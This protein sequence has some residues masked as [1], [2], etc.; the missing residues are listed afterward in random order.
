M[1][2]RTA[3]P[4][5]FGWRMFWEGQARQGCL[6]CRRTLFFF[7]TFSFFY[8][9]LLTSCLSSN[10]VKSL[11]YGITG[12]FGVWLQRRFLST[13]SVELWGAARAQVTVIWTPASQRSQSHARF[14]PQPPTPVMLIATQI[15]GACRSPRLS[16]KS[17]FL[18]A[19]SF[20]WAR[21]RGRENKAQT[22]LHMNARRCV[23]LGIFVP[24]E[25]PGG[26]QRDMA[27]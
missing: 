2:T 10:L 11:A 1:C 7:L 6:M 15:G 19:F 9:V 4:K 18:Q 22:S 8:S 27:N 17:L 25:R 13:A 26:C 12:F 23:F 20:W 21:T 14:P 24:F 16:E 3:I 5:F